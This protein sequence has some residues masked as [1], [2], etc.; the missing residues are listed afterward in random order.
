MADP[1]TVTLIGAPRRCAKC[2]A[3]EALLA[4]LAERFPGRLEVRKYTTDDP[5]AEAYGVILPPVVVVADFLVALGTVPDEERLAQLIQK[6]LEAQ[7]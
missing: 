1:L 2:E 3:C 4:R 5:A 6:K 7:P